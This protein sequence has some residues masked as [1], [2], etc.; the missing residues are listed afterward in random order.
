M[1][2]HVVPAEPRVSPP[3]MTV[4][5]PAVIAALPTVRTSEVAVGAALLA[6]ED[7]GW[8]VGAGEVAENPL[9]CLIVIVPAAG[10]ETVAVWKV[11][12]AETLNRP[13]RGSGHQE[14]NIGHSSCN[15]LRCYRS[16]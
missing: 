15:L 11:M 13:Q 8:T 14:S 5:V 6:M 10:I 16:C 4:Y 9:G 2:L 1:A 7:G 12:V 3:R